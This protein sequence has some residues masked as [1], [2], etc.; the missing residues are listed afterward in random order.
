MLRSWD[1]ISKI[2]EIE[3]TFPRSWK[4][5]FTLPHRFLVI[6]GG[7]SLA[8]SP[9]KF[10]SISTWIPPHSTSLYAVIFTFPWTPPGLHVKTRIDSNS[11]A[12]EMSCV[13]GHGFNFD[14]APSL[15]GIWCPLIYKVGDVGDVGAIGQ[16]FGIRSGVRNKVRGSE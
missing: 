2:T 4:W 16:R 1:S 6:P 9:A 8:G 5:H 10:L 11:G 12:S 13:N 7:I 3:T 15:V 14:V